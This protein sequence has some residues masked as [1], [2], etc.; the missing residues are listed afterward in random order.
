[1]LYT[2]IPQKKKKKDLNSVNLKI[3]PYFLL[4]S[5]KEISRK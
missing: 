3:E 5:E 2:S 4:D 1:M